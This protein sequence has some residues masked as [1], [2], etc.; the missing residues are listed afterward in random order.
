MGPRLSSRREEK[1]IPEQIRGKNYIFLILV[2]KET[3][4]TVHVQ[5]GSSEVKREGASPHSK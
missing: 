5:K 2:V 4:L 3:F 1:L